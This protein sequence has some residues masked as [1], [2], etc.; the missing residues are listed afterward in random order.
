MN[1]LKAKTW[2]E[3]IEA[4]QGIIL[5]E[6]SQQIDLLTSPLPWGPIIDGVQ[7]NEDPFTLI[8]EG[9]FNQIPIITGTTNDEGRFFV[10]SLFTNELSAPD[11]EIFLTTA[12]GAQNI[13]SI[14]DLYSIPNHLSDYRVYIE[15]I[16]GDYLFYCPTLNITKSIS[17]IYKN[18][19]LKRIWLY[20]WE[21]P[22]SF[23]AWGYR[24]PF[25]D[26][27]ACHGIELPFLFSS[28]LLA[29][30]VFTTDEYLLVREI[31][32][33]WSN[34]AKYS[35]PTGFA[36]NLWP[37]FNQSFQRLIIRSS[38]MEIVTEYRSTFCKFWDEYGY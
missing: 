7:M 29:G 28:A 33:F 35:D 32:S 14:K 31:T 21:H 27:H 30:Y 10:Y 38:K 26:G 6:S 2:V 17:I 37:N 5:L 34:M 20:V 13:H 36:E 9:K 12:F 25:C 3:I 8:R 1:C 24:Y 18:D 22:A 11:F 16:V 19:F 23:P 15:D 4:Q